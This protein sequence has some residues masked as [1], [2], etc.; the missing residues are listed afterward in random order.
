MLLITAELKDGFQHSN[1]Q[2]ECR[3][4]ALVRVAEDDNGNIIVLV[5]WEGF[6]SEE[7]SWESLRKI[8]SSLP[9]FVVKELR[10]LRL[11]RA[12]TSK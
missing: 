3:V 7:S 5:D 11:T 6:D 4:N 12:L 2:G 8:D 10:K 9:E 1:A